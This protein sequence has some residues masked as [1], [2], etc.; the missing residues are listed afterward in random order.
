[1]HIVLLLEVIP[2]LL[3]T[4]GKKNPMLCIP[5]FAQLMHPISIMHTVPAEQL[6][7]PTEYD[8]CQWNLLPFNELSGRMQFYVWLLLYQ[9]TFAIIPFCNQLLQE[10][11]GELKPGSH[12]S[13][14]TS[15]SGIASPYRQQHPTICLFRSKYHSA[16]GYLFI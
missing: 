1:M 11:L 15:Q 7:A 5:S 2:L 13:L 8:L 10:L 16:K 14:Y 4:D 12:I 9:D 6:L 3:A